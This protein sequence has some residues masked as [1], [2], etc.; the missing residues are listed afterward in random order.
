[1]PLNVCLDVNKFHVT[2]SA[3][4][5]LRYSKL[6]GSSPHLQRHIPHR[7]KL[8]THRKAYPEM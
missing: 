4:S 8:L 2:V 6:D 3:L 5:V 1:M 7:W